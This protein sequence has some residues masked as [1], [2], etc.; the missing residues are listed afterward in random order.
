MT[1]GW[2]PRRYDLAC[3]VD[4]YRDGWPLA[5][6]LAHRFRYHPAGIWTE[7]IVDGSVRINGRVASPDDP[8]AKGDRVEYTLV[9]AEP[10]VDFAFDVLHEDEQLLAVAKSG[11]L[12]VHAG[13]KF[14][15]NTLIATLRERWGD[16]L[17]PAHRLDRET[18][19][20]VVLAKSRAVAHDL[21][22]EFRKRR[23]DKEYLTVLRGE[24]ADDF[25]VDAPIARGRAVV[26]S[27]RRVV[28]E[29]GQEA[30]T[31]FEVLAARDGLSFVR[32]R[33]ES[34]RTNQIRV[35][36]AHAGHPVLGDKIY[37]VPEEIAAEFVARGETERVLAAAGASRHLLHCRSLS[38]RHP[39][40]GRRITIE[41]PIPADLAAF[42][43]GFAGEPFRGI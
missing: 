34:G 27:Y 23:V 19:G 1:T 41:A 36:A 13:G 3:T 8:V 18:S 37:G 39:A 9:H 15:R 24:I 11:N 6:F 28:V 16:E 5:R 14:I 38:F 33:P 31:R 20:V 35:H 25:V 43:A 7:R 17:R 4:A 2:I 29:G 40:Q 30:V 26:P 22:I 42:S 12:P 32:V 21:E 10:P